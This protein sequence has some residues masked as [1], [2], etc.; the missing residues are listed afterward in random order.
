MKPVSE[1]LLAAQILTSLLNQEGSL[2]SLLQTCRQRH[3]AAAMPLV[4]EL[5]FGVC[6]WFHTLDYLLARQL[7]KPLKN[8]EQLV[9]CLLLVGLY[10]MFYLRVPDHAAVNESVAAAPPWAKALVNAV[11]RNARRQYDEA[12]ASIQA[13]ES[14]LHAHP[15]W[16]LSHLKRDWPNHYLDILA[17]NNARAGMS[18]RVN[19]A[20]ITRQDYLAR[21]SQ[22]GIAA[23]PGQLTVSAV[24]LAE[25]LAVEQI[26]GFS[27]GLV[28]VQDEASQLAAALLMAAPGQRVL[29]ACAAPGGKTCALLEQEPGLELLALDNDPKRLARIQENLDRI[30]PQ[31]LPDSQGQSCDPMG[32]SPARL[33]EADASKP[34]TWWDGQ[35]FDRILLDAPCSGT[36]V[37]RRHPDIKVLRQAGDIADLQARQAA[38]LQALWPTLKPGGRLLYS[39]CSV[40]K[41]ENCRQIAAFLAATPDAREVPLDRGDRLT[42]WGVDCSPGRQL[43]PGPATSHDGFFYALLEK[44]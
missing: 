6:R 29:D 38:M 43:L 4:Q 32:A 24:I 10:Q 27:E 9:R 3:P 28:S 42:P 33:L 2:T 44:Y 23:H 36:G 39:T 15:P 1:R 7:R 19:L 5:C 16:L 25:P 41:D 21:L 30:F 31:S 18:L 8:K 26:P 22:A 20:R 13:D 37:I 12:Q 40:L 17:G 14:R 34:D 11:L 35:H